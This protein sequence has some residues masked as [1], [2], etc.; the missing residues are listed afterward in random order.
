MA[1]PSI[2]VEGHGESGKAATVRPA[3]A[4]SLQPPDQIGQLVNI[5]SGDVEGNELCWEAK[6]A[7]PTV[8]GL[9]DLELSRE[10]VDVEPAVAESGSS[11]LSGK[12]GETVVQELSNTGGSDDDQ[13]LSVIVNRININAVTIRALV[14]VEGQ[15]V[16]AVVDSGAEVTIWSS[17]HYHSL[18]VDKR[19]TLTTPSVKLV[20]A[21]QQ[22]NLPAE[23][24]VLARLCVHTREFDWPVHVAP[25]A[26]PFLLGSDVLDA[27]DISV[28]SRRGLLIDDTWVPCEVTR[29]EIN[30]CRMSVSV[31]NVVVIQPEHE[32]VIWV[33]VGPFKGP[34]ARPAVLE[35]LVEDQRGLL[36]ARC[37]VDLS[38]GEIPVRLVNL[39]NAP[40]KL[41][42]NY[43]LG[44]L[45]FVEQELLK[46]EANSVAVRHLTADAKERTDQDSVSS[47]KQELEG[48]SSNHESGIASDPGHP[49]QESSSVTDTT[50]DA[51]QVIPEHL[52]DLYASAAQ[53]IS[54]PALHNKLQ[55][56]LCRR[57]GAFARHKMDLG[58]FTAICHEI[59][60]GFA[61]PVKER[62]R[63]TPRGFEEEEKKC[64]EEQLEA[65]VIRP[66][67]SPWAAPT[68]LVRKSDGSVRWCIDFRKLN[69]RS[70]KDAYPLPKISMC[71]DSLGGARFFTTLDLQSGYWQIG[72]AESD[73]PKTAFITKYGLYEYTKMPFGLCSAPGTF[74]RCMELVFRG[75]QWQTILIYLDDLIILG[76]TKEENLDHLDVALGRL[77]AAG[78]K[79][80]PSKCHILQPEVLF[81]GHVVSEQG[82]R[83]N[84]QLIDCVRN[85]KPPTSRR[86]V[87]QFLGLANYYRRF[88]PKFSDLAVPL[89][90]L[91]R[92]DQDFK[93][94]EEAQGA[95]QSLTQALCSAP[96]LSFPRETGD[97]VLDT[98]ASATGVGAVLQQIQDGEEKVLAYGSKKLNRQQRNYCV[99][100]RE[101]LAIVVFLREFR[102]YL[103]GQQ[104]LL[105]TDHSSLTWLLRF[106][107]PQGQLARW[108]E[109]IFQF[110]FTIVHRDGRKHTNAD[111]LSRSPPEDGSCDE[112]KLGVPLGD[113]L[114]G[115]C[116]YCTRRH[117]EWQDFAANIDDVIPLA[118]ACR[119]VVT[120]S[121]LAK[122]QKRE[123]QSKK[124]QPHPERDTEDKPCQ[125]QASDATDLPLAFHAASPNWAQ[126]LTL[127]E[128]REAQLKDPDLRLVHEWLTQGARPTREVASAL[129]PDARAYWLNFESLILLEGILHLVWIDP[130]GVKSEI[131]KLVIPR[132]LRSRVLNSCHDTIFSAHLGVNKTVDRVKQ[133]FFWPGLRET[134]KQHIRSCQVCA[135]SKGAYRKFRATLV[136]FRVGAPMDRVAVDIMG[137]LPES[138]RG[139]RYILVIV[140]YFTRWVEAFPLPD[141]KAKTVA[142]KVVCDFIC[143]FGTPLELHTDQGRTFES[144]LFQEICR[145]LEV[146]KTRSTPYHPSA[147]GLVERFN[148][149][150]GSM[151]RSYLDGSCGD[152]DFYIPILTA[153]YRSTSHPATGFSPNLL[154]LG[155]ETMTPTDIQFPREHNVA[156]SIPEYV[157][158]LQE[159]FARCY[160]IARQNLKAAAERQG[161]YHNTRIVQNLFQPGQLVLKRSPGNSKL[162]KP[163]VGPYLVVRMASDCVV[164]ICDKRKSYAVH[165]DLLKP[166]PE[167][168]R[169]KWAKKIQDRP[170][171]L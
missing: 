15:Q 96:I 94:G 88:V 169:P 157:T 87:Q 86:E 23:G 67:S 132:S 99:T 152:W 18:P 95:F 154:M 138:V 98:D 79:L 40:I 66:S 31:R 156:A 104:F 20:V 102:N 100:R 121:Q 144:D 158:G 14:S 7:Q 107:E 63:P 163:W 117:V 124:P 30:V 112:F 105:R 36:V 160:A 147:N 97:F 33:P 120:R 74:Q 119:Q 45:Q 78:L 85:W 61:A 69:D 80:K 75:L 131:R 8:N 123:D 151:I 28:G 164:I 171:G 1:G 58:H 65:G 145:L 47:G 81:L 170:N 60:T 43:P 21:D 42:R 50:Q 37:L 53:G 41:K 127:V 150:L 115:G 118:G 159:Q 76:G 162:S 6:M 141:Q 27:Q 103:L 29:R 136:D 155:R 4:H 153:A 12:A 135:V 44:E 11:V 64:L 161:K 139:N 111:A 143:R 106:K 146:T 10:A 101:L 168:A 51:A 109:Y 19:P 73:I 114:C 125:A 34:A 59:N 57:Q 84:P 77:E 149:T 71:L 113:L 62:V 92:K 46:I 56:I 126:G 49:L 167:E 55:D 133:R 108:L 2:V 148:R 52:K 142:H 93:W 140:D 110:K 17:Q 35:P 130:T 68:V 54:D 116:A 72:M 39:T 134:V 122:Q 32:M 129:S 70:V 22:Q 16:R 38:Q 5:P 3:V 48:A 128:L 24:V 83:P 89:T 166:C 91:T 13:R 165:H 137:P 90:E 82:M 25:I 26:D 9:A